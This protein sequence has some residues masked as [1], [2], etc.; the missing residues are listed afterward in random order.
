MDRHAA[1]AG[2]PRPALGR[3][4]D[5]RGRAYDDGPGAQLLERAQSGRNAAL[6]AAD[7]EKDQVRLAL[8]RTYKAPLTRLLVPRRYTTNNGNSPTN[9]D[10]RGNPELRPELAWGLD[11]GYE[12]YFGKDGVASVSAYVRRVQGVTVQY[13][14]PVIRPW[15]STPTNKGN[16]NVAGI[17]A[18]TK[19][20]PQRDLD[21]HANL[22]YN[23]SALDAVPGPYNRLADQVPGTAN[24][25][26]DYRAT[27]A[28]TFGANL[29][30][31]FG[32]QVRSSEQQR[33]YTG[34]L[35][36][37]DMYAL[38][39]FDEQTKWGLSVA[40]ALQQDQVSER[41]YADE[42]G[43]FQ[44]RLVETNRIVIRLVLEKRL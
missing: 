25:G 5:P 32:G 28:V 41:S 20:T 31:Q 14:D 7:C 6:E 19:F 43:S 22:G 17:E 23:W 12:K 36:N 3:F 16:A 26:V 40:E 44:R 39:K 42:N 38:W 33:A 10:V 27:A 30:L 18:D 1:L 35:R 8:S 9:P 4:A 15:L 29:N 37:L 21:L 13:V 24:A 2:L 11:T 34:P